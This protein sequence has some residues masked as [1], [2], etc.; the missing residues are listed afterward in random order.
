MSAFQ[1]RTVGG[2]VVAVAIVVLSIV[3]SGSRYAL[4]SVTDDVV[5]GGFAAGYPRYENPV[6]RQ[7]P[8]GAT[9]DGAWLGWVIGASAALPL[10]LGLGWWI[11]SLSRRDLEGTAADSD[12]GGPAHGMPGTEGSSES[13]AGRVDGSR[14]ERA[15][16]EVEAMV[17]AQGVQLPAS[18]TTRSTG[19]LAVE[20]G[21]PAIK[22]RELARAY[23]LD[24]YSGQPKEV[25]ADA[26]SRLAQEIIRG[27]SE[28]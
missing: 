22:V 3:A 1:T 11:R 10:L 6:E 21:S 24:R 27:R 4:F 18:R 9:G 5:A 20:L 14:V 17:V 25:D 15:W 28:R 7:R 2:L 8:D 12:E 13:C 26:A 19:E 16:R 23:D